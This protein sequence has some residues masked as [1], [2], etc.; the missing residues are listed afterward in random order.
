MVIGNMHKKFGKIARVVSEISLRTYRQT[1]TD[2]LININDLIVLL[3]HF[4]VK[5]KLFADDVKLY[6]KVVN[7]FAVDKLQTALTGLSQCADEW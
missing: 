3:S 7:A 4:A 1:Y 6:V 2:T 5:V